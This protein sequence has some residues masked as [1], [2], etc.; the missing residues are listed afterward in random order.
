MKLETSF[1]FDSAHRLVGYEGA[2]S[3]LHGH[4]WHVDLEIYGDKKNLDN[5]GI[6][7]DFTN[8]K[9][10]KN[11]FDHKTILKIC[12]ENEGLVYAI[13]KACGSDSLY[14]MKENP[15]AENL[16]EEILIKLKENNNNLKYKVRVYESPKSYV[17]NEI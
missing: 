5:V 17:E 4:I 15:T 2:C 1:D 12:K 13:T 14:L 16:T 11:L 6:L 8:A 7:W 10:L 3:R 9:K